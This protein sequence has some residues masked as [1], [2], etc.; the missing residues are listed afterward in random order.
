VAPAKKD[1]VLAIPGHLS[2]TSLIL[3]AGLKYDEWESV[4]KTLRTIEGAVQWWLGDWVNYGERSYGEKYSQ[5]L[6]ET[7]YSYG[8][9]RDFAWVAH[10]VEMSR[11]RDNLSFGHH[12]EVASLLPSDQDRWLTRAANERLT[13]DQLRAALKRP[14]NK[15]LP[16][17][18]AGKF[19]CLVVDPPWPMD[20]I[21]RETRPKQGAGLD[22]ITMSL[23]RIAILPVPTLADETGAH[24]YL[25][26]TQ[27]FLPDAMRFVETWGFTYVAT[28]TWV[29]P[30]G[31]MPFNG[32]RYN[33]EF[34][35]FATRGDCPMVSKEGT[36][37]AFE[38][39]SICRRLFASDSTSHLRMM[40]CIERPTLSC[41]SMRSPWP[42]AFA[43]LSVADLTTSQYARGPVA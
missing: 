5:A 7:D 24:L 40:I 26:T 13:R 41:G 28:F 23:D 18:P 6:D 35:L 14:T 16:P 9:L 11:R 19:R 15:A 3:R 29:K 17:L 36:D 21:V 10:S 32:L 30:T 8:T 2:P 27:R 39:Q 34:A 37:L 33:N 22:Y 43:G 12:R 20:K 25:W 4:G 1:T 38:A 42:L 31:I